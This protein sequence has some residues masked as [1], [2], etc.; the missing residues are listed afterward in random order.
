VKVLS[1]SSAQVIS[2]GQVFFCKRFLKNRNL[3]QPAEPD[4]GS[5]GISMKRRKIDESA[6]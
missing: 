1:T 5:A 3:A 2:W 6:L 4:P